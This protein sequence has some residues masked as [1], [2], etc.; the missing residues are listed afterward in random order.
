[1]K[2][3]SV[4]AAALLLAAPL[5]AAAQHS[6]TPGTA[7]H[8]HKAAGETHAHAS[9]HGGVVRTAGQ[10][11]LEL[12]QQAGQLQVYLLDGNE[13]TL[14]VTR[15][16]GT[17]LLLSAAGKTSSVKLLPTGNHLGAT[18]PAGFTLRTAIVSV[19]ANGN[20]LSARFE[21][22]EAAAKAG[23]SVSAAYACPMSCPGSVSAKPGSCPKCGMAL[24]KKS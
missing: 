6:H 11:H 1:M 20:S 18:V 13:K 24:V 21:K 17:A 4:L 16:T 15:A 10:Y 5:T 8:G 22:L 14:P 12:V 3:S 9:P 19:K 7:A 23:K 2:T